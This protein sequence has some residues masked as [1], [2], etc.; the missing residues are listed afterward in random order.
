LD[1]D[2]RKPT[3]RD[4]SLLLHRL[5]LLDIQW[6]EQER[7]TGKAGTFH[8]VWR[9]AWRPELPVDVIAAAIW[10]NTV[11]LAASACVCDRAA[12]LATLPELTALLEGALK[13]ALGA[14]IPDLI[15]RLQTESAIAP[16]LAHLMRA[17]PALA[18]VTRYALLQNIGNCKNQ[19]TMHGPKAPKRGLR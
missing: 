9:I 4:R 16:D 8:E 1:L 10:G 7:V 3:D 2:L 11:E 17:L 14:A 5:R 19:R 15:R 12:K 18:R 6:G 13:A